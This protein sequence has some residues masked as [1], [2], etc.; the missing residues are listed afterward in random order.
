VSFWPAA[1]FCRRL[2]V[3]LKPNEPLR[4]AVMQTSAGRSE[5]ARVDRGLRLVPALLFVSGAI[6]L[7]YEVVWQRQLALLFGSA[8][9]ATGAVLAAYFAGLGLGSVVD[10]RLAERWRRSLGV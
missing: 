8:S 10:G 6:A 3:E 4:A 2:F 9:P 5:P 7:V 1:I